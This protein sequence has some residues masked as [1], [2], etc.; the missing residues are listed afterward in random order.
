VVRN[1]EEGKLGMHAGQGFYDFRDIDV[2]AYQRDML[3]RFVHLLRHM[4]LVP[5]PAEE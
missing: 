5:P 2:E 3:T 4:N 1:M